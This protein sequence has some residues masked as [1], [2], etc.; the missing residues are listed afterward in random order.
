MNHYKSWLSKQNDPRD[1]S[2]RSF[3]DESTHKTENIL[4][5]IDAT[6]KTVEKV[7]KSAVSTSHGHMDDRLLH[8]VTQNL[9][10]FIRDAPR[11]EICKIDV[12]FYSVVGGMFQRENGHKFEPCI[13]RGIRALLKDNKHVTIHPK[14]KFDGGWFGSKSIYSALDKSRALT[15]QMR[16]EESNN[17]NLCLIHIHCTDS[18]HITRG[19]TDQIIAQIRRCMYGVW[20]LHPRNASEKCNF[21][22]AL[23]YITL[24]K[25]ESSNQ[26]TED[27]FSKEMFFKKN[28]LSS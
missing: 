19:I 2:L 8:R 9:H 4:K 11:N 14:L 17:K 12:R 24:P 26:T 10:R 7:A 18:T 13:K 22:I 3:L 20:T 6:P 21:S 16:D 28:V 1:Q 15:V 27:V 25:Q 23:K 5:A